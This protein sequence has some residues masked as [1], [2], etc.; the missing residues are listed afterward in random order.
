MCLNF[1]HARFL[2][3]HPLSS[4]VLCGQPD[5]WKQGPVT[6]RDLDLNLEIRD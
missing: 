6:G 3:Q 4:R 2:E 1:D 5:A